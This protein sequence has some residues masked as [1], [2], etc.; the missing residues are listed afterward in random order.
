MSLNSLANQVDYFRTVLALSDTHNI[1]TLLKSE[2][3]VPSTQPYNLSDV[4]AALSRSTGLTQFVIDCD[5]QKTPKAKL[6][7]EIRMCYSLAYKP[8]D[9]PLDL[10]SE[11]NCGKDERTIV[12]YLPFP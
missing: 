10:I 1:F 12:Y 8:V 11:N 7:S 6:I 2:G 4:R 3:I 9:C 5:T